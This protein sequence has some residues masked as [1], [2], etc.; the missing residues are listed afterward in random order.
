MNITPA[1]SIVSRLNSLFSRPNTFFGRR[2]AMSAR[3]GTCRK[4][5]TKH[6]LTPLHH[7]PLHSYTTMFC[8][9]T[10]NVL[11]RHMQCKVKSQAM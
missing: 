2:E 9:S 4:V 10:Y 1:K 11:P 7:V 3:N 6:G 5:L 8:Q